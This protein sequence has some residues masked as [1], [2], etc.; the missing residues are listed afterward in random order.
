[1]TRH[2]LLRLR[3]RAFMYVR[4][5]LLAMVFAMI[6]AAALAA[7]S[8]VAQSTT[9][10][11]LFLSTSVPNGQGAF[12]RGITTYTV[13][14]TTGALTQITPP[15][16]QTRAAPGALAINNA[17]TFLF[18]T[19]T[20]SASQGAMESFSVGSDGSL[21]EVGTSPYTI[22]NPLATPVT[23][24]VSPNGQYLYVASSVPA[25]ENLPDELPQSTI[26]DVFAVAADGSLTL[27]ATFPYIAVEICDQ[28]TPAPATPIQL[29]VHPTQ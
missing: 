28:T 29:L 27:S 19:A 6:W 11:Y 25:N 7:P 1:M 10:Q 8:A 20:N 4:V 15:P 3:A 18:A 21:T 5:C 22:S 16:V 13:D 9:P 24:A 12:V 14:T 26:L 2:D 17:G 23:L